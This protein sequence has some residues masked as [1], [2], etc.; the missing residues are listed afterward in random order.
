MYPHGD[1]TTK[2]DRINAVNHRIFD[3]HIVSVTKGES[4]WVFG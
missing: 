1:N 3:D 2:R 4:L